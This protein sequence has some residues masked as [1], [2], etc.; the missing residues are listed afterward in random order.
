MSGQE[1][2][3]E[4]LQRARLDA[5]GIDQG[6]V[7]E[8]VHQLGGEHDGEDDEGEDPDV[9]AQADARAVLEDDGEDHADHFPDE[10]AHIRDDVQDAGDEGDAQGVREAQPGDDPQAQE[11]Q[12]GDAGHLHQQAHEIAGKKAL[13]VPQGLRQLP[14]HPVRD[15]GA[16]DLPEQGFVAHEEEGDEDDG[17]KAHDEAGHEGG[18]GTDDRR[19]VGHVRHLPQLVHQDG[20]DIEVRSE[21]REQ[22]HDPVIDP[23]QGISVGRDAVQHRGVP[24][25]ARHDRDDLRHHQDE[26]SEDDEDREDGEQPVRRGLAPDADL[27]EQPHHGLADQRHHERHDDVH[28]DVLEIPAQARQDGEGRRDD[29]VPGQPVD[30][31]FLFHSIQI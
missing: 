16:D 2:D 10:R 5:G 1:D 9:H 13:D 6:L 24:D 25:D 19:D 15:Q 12:Q 28:E 4:D 11:I 8:V 29:D 7:H 3:D 27:P 30:A 22:A 21:A 18:H 31:S 26:G 14:F 23:V 17:E 20:D